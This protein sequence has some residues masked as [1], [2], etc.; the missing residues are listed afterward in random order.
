MA[1]LPIVVAF[2]SG[3]G[4]PT[5]QGS[6]T[7]QSC[8]AISTCGSGTC[9]SGMTLV[10]PPVRSDTYTLRTGRGALPVSDPNDYVPGELLTLYMS[11]TRRMI[12]G[13]EQAGARIVANETAKYIGL[14]VYAVRANDATERKVGGWELPLESNPKLWTP[15]DAPGCNGRALM[16]AG[17]EAK[18]YTERLIFRAPPA[19][20]GPITFRALVKQGETN[21]GA[22]YWPVAPAS[23]TP[24]LQPVAGL[25]NGDLTLLERPTPPPTRRWAHRAADESQTCRQVCAQQQMNC[26]REPLISMNSASQLAAAVGPSFLCAPPLYATCS[27]AAP[28]MSGLGDG[29]C[30]YRES[31][32]PARTQPDPCDAL[33]SVGFDSGLRL[34]PCVAPGAQP[35][36]CLANQP[37][38]SA[39]GGIYYIDGTSAPMSYGDGYRAMSIT[40]GAAHPLRFLHAGGLAQC[41][42][43]MTPLAASS[44]GGAGTV[45]TLSG[46]LDNGVS[47]PYYYG[48]WAAT[49][50]SDPACRAH[51]LSL[52]CGLHGYMGGQNRLVWDDGC[53]TAGRRLDEVDATADMPPDAL[54]HDGTDRD[55]EADGA[56][57]GD[58]E[59]CD[60]AQAKP[61]APRVPHSAH[62]TRGGSPLRCPS[63][64]AAA[65]STAATTSLPTDDAAKRATNPLWS[66]VRSLAPSQTL[67]V[68]GLMI[69]LMVCLGLCLGINRLGSDRRRRRA[70]PSKGGAGRPVASALTST[71]AMASLPGVR[72]HNWIHG[73]SSRARNTASTIKPCPANTAT[74]PHLQVNAEQK[75]IMEW[76]TGHGGPTFFIF[77]RAGDERMLNTISRP[78]LWRYLFEAPPEAHMYFNGIENNRFSP[79][80]TADPVWLKVHLRRYRVAD[81]HWHLGPNQMFRMPENHRSMLMLG[82]RRPWGRDRWDYLGYTEAKRGTDRR[83]AYHNPA[84]RTSV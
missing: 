82:D 38:I 35:P 9:P 56:S 41:L 74:V 20:T 39:A 6:P 23:Y 84:V 60:N 30:W 76:A 13:K 83:V 55:D 66:S 54:G 44:Q 16:H 27:E 10:A 3:G 11:V 51:A 28:R 19:G 33:P 78:L 46:P 22:F 18:R 72:P 58:G 15:P 29:M 31:T 68:G 79:N 62:G 64:R 34:C 4:D 77:L 65:A 61:S 36:G 32:C 42:P 43:T 17:A 57:S 8:D 45:V 63:M 75:F 26:E 1:W 59:P 52:M 14:L 2:S 47:Y 70:I 73:V 40:A 49:F 5:R 7:L 21:K 69:C 67:L 48:N 80:A 81:N 12:P 71:L 37:T 25:P 24:N 50:S 53:Q